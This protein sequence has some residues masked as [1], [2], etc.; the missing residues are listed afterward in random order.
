MCKGLGVEPTPVPAPGG[1]N[2]FNMGG[3]FVFYYASSIP[4]LGIQAGEAYYLGYAYKDVL[5]EIKRVFLEFP[6]ADQKQ[7]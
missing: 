3:L 5:V 4:K 2:E 1:V 7:V 6:A